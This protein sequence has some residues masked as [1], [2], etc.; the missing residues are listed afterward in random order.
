MGAFDGTD[1]VGA[2]T[3]TPLADHAEGVVQAL[4][5]LGVPPEEVFYLAESVLLPDYHGRGIGHAF[6]E[7]REGHARRH[8]YR[9]AAFASVIRPDDH[10][11]RPA[12]P[13]DLGPFWRKRGYVPV[14]GAIARLSWRDIGE[15]R[16]T[17]KALSV[18]MREL[19]ATGS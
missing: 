13:R 2:S 9:T 5:R 19:G 4:E 7:M 14:E 8:G 1:L 11:R 15:S 6:F 10:P 3:G 17:E 18:W 16:E 12:M